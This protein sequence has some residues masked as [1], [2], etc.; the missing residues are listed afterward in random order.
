[1]PTSLAT[2]EPFFFAGGDTGCLMIH[3]F[4]GSPAETYELGQQLAARGHTVCGVRLAGHGG[5]AEA[6]Y[7]SRWPAWLAS[8]EQG[9]DQLRPRCRQVVVVGFSLG[10]VLG[11]LLTQRRPVAGLVTMGSRVLVGRTPRFVLAPLLRHVVGWRDPSL[12]ATA[13]LGGAVRHARRVLPLVQVPALVMHG[14]D[15]AI[16]AP[17][18]AEAILRGLASAQ[19]E[20]VWWDNTGHQM[21]VE[22]PHRAE[23][24]ARIVAFVAGL[25]PL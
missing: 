9:Y 17:A 22:G 6:F 21:L 8:V 7:Q 2:T 5:T 10:G 12:G 1:M 13:E 4:G 25:T 3:G 24:Y 11:L 14:R 23:V 15:D 19:K 16:V 18:N 20:L